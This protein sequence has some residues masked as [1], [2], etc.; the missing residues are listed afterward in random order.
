MRIRHFLASLV[1]LLA[2]SGIGYSQTVAVQD[3][4]GTTNNRNS[5]RRFIFPNGTVSITGPI[6]TI[7]NLAPILGATSQKS[8]T[9][10]ADANVLTVTPPAAV[11]TYRLSIDISVSAATSGVIGWTATWTDANGN[12]QT[13]TEL[14][15][16][17]NGT[18]APALTFTTSAAGNYH[19][20]VVIDVNNAGTNIVIKWIGGGTTTA[21][22]SAVVERLN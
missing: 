8:E 15:L 7:S 20:T 3:T 17:Q 5:I 1:V 16:F 11:G 2:V 22:M 4:T 14:E 12:A 10:T 19:S 18:A 21:K 13:P 6:A 9:T